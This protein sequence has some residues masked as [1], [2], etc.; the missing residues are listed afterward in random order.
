LR[1][2]VASKSNSFFWSIPD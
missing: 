2:K 1:K